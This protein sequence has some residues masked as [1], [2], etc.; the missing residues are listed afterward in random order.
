MQTSLGYHIIDKRSLAVHIAV[1][2]QEFH[3][4]QAVIYFERFDLKVILFFSIFR[5]FRQYNETFFTNNR[6]TD[7]G[8]LLPLSV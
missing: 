1:N 2:F 8:V 5:I 3:A 4:M 7:Q 6:T